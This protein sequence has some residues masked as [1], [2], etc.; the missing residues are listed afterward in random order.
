MRLLVLL[1]V[2]CLEGCGLSFEAYN[3]T[4]YHSDEDCLY[5]PECD[6]FIEAWDQYECETYDCWEDQ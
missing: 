5:D 6:E 1:M 2:V 3:K 4:E